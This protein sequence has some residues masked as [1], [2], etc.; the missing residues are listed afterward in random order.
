MN[1]LLLVD[2]PKGPTSHDIVLHIR[3]QLPRGVKVGHSGTLDPL[4]TGLLVILIGAA[5]KLAEKLQ[6]LP[7]VY[8]G[9]VRLGTATDSGDLAGKVTAESPV[10]VVAETEIRAGMDRL[11]GTLKMNPPMYSAV[12]YQG[13]PLYDYARK[14]VEVPLK[15]RSCE[16]A[17]W[18]LLDWKSPEI[19]FRVYC[20]HGTYVRTLAELLGKELSCPAVLSSLRREKIGQFDIAQALS[21]DQ[22]VTAAI[23]AKIIPLSPSMA[24]L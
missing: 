12:K 20:S 24:N 23:A 21:M 7:K 15:E 6:K 14:G 17:R 18:E 22:V 4:A 5:T 10:P 19:G 8:S 16:I 1:G 9:T 2:K 3:R 13:K 11:V